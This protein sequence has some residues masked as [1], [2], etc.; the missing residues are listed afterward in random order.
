MDQ[1]NVK[2][3]LAWT[4]QAKSYLHSLVATLFEQ[5]RLLYVHSSLAY[6]SASTLSLQHL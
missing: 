2:L 5:S 3:Q 4:Q 6:V 1:T